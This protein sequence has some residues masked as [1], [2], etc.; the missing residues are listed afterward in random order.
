[1]P[2]TKISSHVI[3]SGAILA[4]HVTGL[5]SADIAEG[6]SNLYYT[7]ARA[8]SAISVTSSGDGLLEYNPATGVIDY[9]GPSAAEVRAHF[10][11]GTGVTYVDGQFSIGQPVG[12]T[13]DVSF[14]SV[15]ATDATFDSIQITG[16]TGTQ[17]TLSWNAEDETIDLIV[18]PDVT[19]QLGQ[20]TG[21]V[22]RN[23]SGQTLNNGA[24]VRVTGASG[25][26]IT[27]DLATANTELG[28]APTI[29]VVTESIDNNSTGRITTA[30]L[31]RDL[32]TSLLTE[33]AAIY[34]GA[35]GAITATPPTSPAH[36]VHIGWVVR[37]HA[38]EGAILVHVNN[39]WEIEELHDVLI[40]GLTDNELLQW[41]AA[42]SVWENRTIAE[43]GLATSAQGALADSALQSGDNISELNNDSAYI[44]GNQTITLTGD[45]SG[46]GTTSIAVTIAD[47]SHNHTIANVDGLQAALDAKLDDSQK[48]AAN[49]LAELDGSGKVP[50]AQLPSYV[51]DVLEYANSGSFPGTG[52][53]GK[54][55]IALDTNDVYRWTGSAYVKVSDAVST[56]DEANTLA[57]A[58]TISLAGDVTGSTSFDGSAN[59]S[60]T[61]TVADDSHNHVIANVDGLQAALDGKQ[62]AG[63]YNTIIGTDSDINTSG[64]TIIDNIFVTD[65]VITSMGTRTLT[66]GDLGYTG[67][68]NATADQTASEILTAI[69]TVD[70]SGSGLDADTVDGVQA[71]SFL[72]TTDQSVVVSTS[73]TSTS[74]LNSI[75]DGWYKWTSNNPTNSPFDYAILLQASDNSQKN[76]LAFGGSGTGK[77][78]VRRADSGTFY[79]WAYFWNEDNDG[80]GSGLDADLLDGQQGSYY[81]SPANAPDPTLTLSGDVTGSATFTN[82]GNA[83]LT[84]TVADDSHNHVI[85]NVDGLQAAL[86][87]K[88]PLSGGTL[89]GNLDVNGRLGAQRLVLDNSER[90]SYSLENGLLIFD[91]AGDNNLNVYNINLGRWVKIWDDSNHGSGSGLDADTVDGIQASSFLRSDAVDTGVALKLTGG[92][93]SSGID[94]ATIALAIDQGDYIYSD[95]GNSL[96][97]I[98]GHT[99]GG[100]IEVGQSGTA[101]FS[102]INFLPG[103]AG[104]SAVKVNGNTVWNAGNDGSGSGLDADLLDGQQGSY[105]YPA[106]N[107]NGYTD[108]QTASEILTAIKTVDGSGSGL[109]AD[110]LDGINS[111]SFLRSDADDTLTGNLQINSHVINMNLG[112]IN[113]NAI[114]LTSVRSS[115]WPF[116][117]TT[118]AVGNDNSSGFWVGGNGYPDMRLRRQNS[119]VRALISSW[120]TSYVS[121]GFNINGNTAWHAGNDGSGSGLDADLLDGIQASSFLRSDTTDT[122]THINSPIFSG[123]ISTSGD[124]QNNYPFRL[125]SDYNSYMVAVANNTWGLFWAGSSGA[126]YGTN[127]NGGPGNIWGNSGNPNEFCFVGGDSTAWTVYGN[128]GDTWQKGTA[129][130]ADQGILWGAS[131]DG[132]GS[133]LDADLLDGQQGSYYYSP[134]NAPDPTLTLSGDA[135]GSATF[136]NLGNATLSVT[137]ANDSHTHDGRYF[138]ETESD[139]RYWRKNET[140]SG[141]DFGPWYSTSAYIYDSTNGTRFF[142]ILLGTIASSGCRGSIEYEAK[143]DAN[144]PHFVK[145]TIAYGG[146]NSGTS[147]SVQHDQHTQDPFG[148][149]VRLD[150][151]RRIWIRVPSC[152]WSHYFRFRVH[153]QSGN[154]TTNTSWSTGSTRYD[155]VSNSVPPNSSNDILSGQNLRATSSSVTGAVPSYGNLNYFGRVYARQDMQVAG[156][157]VWHAGNDG[158]GSGLD[159]DLLDGVHA[160]SF[161]RVDSASTQNFTG[162]IKVSSNN[163]TGGGIILADDGDM[164]DLNDGYCSMRFS[165]GVRVFSANRGGSAVHTLH[166]NGSFTASGNVTAYSDIRLKENIEVIPNALEKVQKIRG[167]TFTRNDQE[168]KEKL[169]TGV[170]AQE[171][172]AV[173][174]EAV[175]EDSDGIKNVAYGNM[176][177]LLIESIKEQQTQIE[178]LT[179]QVN[180]LKEL[181]NSNI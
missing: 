129:R 61:A 123:N 66:L 14:A 93:Y 86:D 109:D 36:L 12:I 147:F 150:T 125:T 118:Q 87:G 6:I 95:N 149:Q 130:T 120:E 166:S 7:D 178:E 5:T 47:D 13:D 111:G 148:V 54:I 23:L 68:T 114:D 44:S 89:T 76:Q 84:A 31:V 169:H 88:L 141:A 39:G 40:S 38:T 49:G 136:T 22:A 92:S 10:S 172:E 162:S 105:Y 165:L 115:T 16:G 80:S 69:K 52:E 65:G 91:Q 15:T 138:T 26:K 164:V 104:N 37:A 70:G 155:T 32:D 152:D 133:G 3:E 17:G 75:S 30:G 175:S 176:V 174:P 53:T 112:N 151:S 28:S 132:S 153:N 20:E 137:V 103:T 63:T 71:S 21:V 116:R 64:S 79:D 117:F 140:G 106:S 146:F 4:T 181:L 94:T 170:I 157:T 57:T 2:I 8:R 72:K 55:Y 50:S 43:A 167:V 113:D 97:R 77:L 78:A 46:S 60:I 98:L 34:L 11:A 58:R 161:A 154:F 171:V 168:D 19:Y 160:S 135:T 100:V 33:G 81:Y 158:S 25:N 62:A 119:T 156:S 134:A 179:S 110:L 1:M 108:D 163:T 35:D 107:P 122:A 180:A 56:A 45:V 24:V 101:L 48:G 73:L 121:N 83:T 126:R 82:L 9:T 96:R 139:S 41:N 27:V 67:E 124:G 159:A 51:D 99:T 173:L 128:S 145:G 90:T 42:S 144:Y 131:N 177:G 85:S 142:W 18:S 102:S 143:D 74:N 127:G 29:G 59:V